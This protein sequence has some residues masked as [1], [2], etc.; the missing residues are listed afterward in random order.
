MTLIFNIEDF[1]DLRIQIIKLFPTLNNNT[2]RDNNF[3]CDFSKSDLSIDWENQVGKIIPKHLYSEQIIYHENTRYFDDLPEEVKY[4]EVRASKILPSSIMILFDIELDIAATNKF[5]LIK[6]K[7]PLSVVEFS[8]IFPWM[9][10]KSPYCE[11]S[12]LEPFI[13]IYNKY[14]EDL[15]SRI[16][17]CLCP[18]V[19]GHFYK[20]SRGE[21]LK[22]LSV[23]AFTVNRSNN[24]DIS[25]NNWLIQSTS[26]VNIYGNHIYNSIISSRIFY[27]NG[28]TF[29]PSINKKSS[30]IF[31]DLNTF[32]NDENIS[33]YI[34]PENMSYCRSLELIAS[35]SSSL[36][37]VE[38]IS[39]LENHLSRERSIIFKK[40]NQ[41]FI[42]RFFESEKAF[43]LL[44]KNLLIIERL[45]MEMHQNRR[46]LN[47]R[48]N[49][50]P[51]ERIFI[52]MVGLNK[53]SIS[54]QSDEE[55]ESLSKFIF[56]QIK[57]KQNYL[58]KYSRF[59]KEYYSEYLS[60]K[61]TEAINT[62]TFAATIIGFLSFIGFD[63][64]I[65]YFNYII[66]LLF[67]VL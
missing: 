32:I 64:V 3:L 42:G 7:K 51:L 37:I 49:K 57:Y 14:F 35:I 58:L 17:D 45:I 55:K 56:S 67:S 28:I 10:L 44:N 30:C 5:S 19:R 53:L 39:T 36:A 25:F 2:I 11:N 16:E 40:I 48:M 41:N 20:N 26:D 8:N 52:K 23:R 9:I 13:E 24:L 47:S 31:L 61:N 1:D 27:K 21:K 60:H 4:I 50:I 34:T 46:M 62:L 65:K 43:I 38:L 63:R 22:F 33:A 66:Y 15:Q 12:N 59:M 54:E 29:I 18:Y 6:S